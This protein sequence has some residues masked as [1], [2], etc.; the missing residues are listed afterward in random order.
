MVQQYFGCLNIKE[1]YDMFLPFR[2][3]HLLMVVLLMSFGA[4][5]SLR[6]GEGKCI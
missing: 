3:G 1:V 5:P 4:D 6:D 2:Q